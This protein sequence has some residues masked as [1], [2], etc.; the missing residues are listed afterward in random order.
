MKKRLIILPVVATM[1]SGCIGAKHYDE[2]EYMMT[3]TWKNRATTD[4]KILQLS[5]I[6]LSQSDAHEQHFEVIDRTIKAAK[7]NLIVLNGDIFTFADKHVVNKF[8]KFI[9]SHQIPWTYTFGNH[10]DQGY[11]NDMYIPRLLS[12]KEKF[13][14][15]YMKNLEDD[16]VTGRT[17]FVINIK[18]DDTKKIVHQV[19]MLDSHSYN[20]ETMKYDALKQDQLEWYERVVKYSTKELG[21]GTPILSSMYMHIGFP[22]VMDPWDQN[23]DKDHQD[24]LIIGDME[25]WGGSPDTDPGFF[26]SVK[27]L[28]STKSVH[29]AH[30]HAN[31]SVMLYQGV[32]ICF[33]V[34]GTNRIYNDEKGVKLGGQVISVDSLGKMEFQNIYVSYENKNVIT[35]QSEGWAK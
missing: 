6:H 9:D 28:G 20:F 33:G 13:G 22:E 29:V 35:K 10:D 4:F 25:E 18:D 11:Y 23:K 17:N 12:E 5:D 15:A 3:L 7:P 30:D 1:L 31:D 26:K 24:G 19:Y 2:K 16:D 21:G 32:Y 14:Y 27:K 8:F 34:H